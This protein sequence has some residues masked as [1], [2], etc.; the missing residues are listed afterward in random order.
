ML[1]LNHES[2]TNA[3]ANIYISEI[4]SPYKQVR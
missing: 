3:K 1:K 4:T 2:D